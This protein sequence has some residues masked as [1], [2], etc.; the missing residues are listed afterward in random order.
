MSRNRTDWEELVI[1]VR[2]SYNA[3]VHI[4]TGL[5]PY[6]CLFMREYKAPQDYL[7]HQYIEENDYQ[8]DPDSK[9]KECLLRMRAAYFYV[10][11][12]MERA[13]RVVEQRFKGHIRELDV[14]MKV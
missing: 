14:G 6:F 9:I 11:D 7:K 1:P 10:E 8:R 2:A 3:N 12:N 13:D 4:S 5:S